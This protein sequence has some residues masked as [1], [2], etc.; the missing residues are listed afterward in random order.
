MLEPIQYFVQLLLLCNEQVLQLSQ[1]WRI[2]FPTVQCHAHLLLLASHIARCCCRGAISSV[3]RNTWRA[4]WC[5]KAPVLNGAVSHWGREAVN[6]FTAGNCNQQET[7]ICSL[8]GSE[9]R[10]TK[11]A[12]YNACVYLCLNLCVSF[13]FRNHSDQD[14]S[15]SPT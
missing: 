9:R 8:P 5:W 3:H 10:L 11:S 13:C 7:E 6:S 14:Q 12:L 1:P 2:C 15:L 4:A